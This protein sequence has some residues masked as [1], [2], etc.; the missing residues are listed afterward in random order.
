MC[1]A[2]SSN[3]EL[4]KNTPN[5]RSCE[6][7]RK[8]ISSPLSAFL[9]LQLFTQNCISSNLDNLTVH[10]YLVSALTQFLGLTGAAISFDI[11]KVQNDVCWIRLARED[12]SAVLAAVS[13]WHGTS[14]D[15]GKLGWI[16]KA[17]GYWLSCL[18]PRQES[19]IFND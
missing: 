4:S 10:S 5:L 17:K 9:C 2:K 3:H 14:S 7:I 1:A 15:S 16:V 8:T 12:M 13:S 11:L 6:I 19:E 18:I